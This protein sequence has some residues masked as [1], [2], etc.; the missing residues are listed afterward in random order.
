MKLP[1]GVYDVL[2]Y[3]VQIVLPAIGALYYGL[4]N[5]WNLAYTEQIVGSIAVVCT[6]LGALLGISTH[7]YYKDNDAG[8]P[9]PPP[10]DHI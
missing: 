3:I 2:K 7:Y 1:N 5:I 9:I 8:G 6:F 4:S 10:T